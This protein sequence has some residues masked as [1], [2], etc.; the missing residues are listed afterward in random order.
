MG[1]RCPDWGKYRQVL[2]TNYRD[3]VLVGQ[4]AN[5]H[6]VKMETYRLA[7][8]EAT[9]WAG[10]ADPHALVQEHGECLVEYFQRVMLHAAP[11]ASPLDVRIGDIRVRSIEFALD[12]EL[13][14]AGRTFLTNLM[15]S[16]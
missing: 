1:S 14:S 12:G 10:T 4:D 9:F 15:G 5:R 11:L 3:F 7:P 16:F 13:E 2:V 8:S 6:A